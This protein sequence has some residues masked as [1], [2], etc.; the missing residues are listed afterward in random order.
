MVSHVDKHFVSAQDVFHLS[1]EL[2][3][4]VAESGYAPQLVVGVWRGGA[5]ASLVVHE[6]LQQIN[7]TCQSTVVVASSY[8]SIAQR[9]S[10]VMIEGLPALINQCE[11]VSRVL[12]VDDLVDSGHTLTTLKNALSESNSQLDV[13]T[14]VLFQKPNA[15]MTADYFVARDE[16]WIV[17]PHELSGLSDQECGQHTHISATQLARLKALRAN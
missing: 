3:L 10:D 1:T 5:V 9:N 6:I 8:M 7:Q 11:S 15:D 13:R 16:R 12:V 14:A 17:F 4:A 2:G